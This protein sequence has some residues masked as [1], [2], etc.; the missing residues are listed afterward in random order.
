MDATHP[1]L[2]VRN[3]TKEFH[4]HLVDGRTITPFAG[5][6]FSVPE[7]SLCM[8]AGR[9][10]AGK[11]T[12]LR[13]IY[14]TYLTTAG[15][16]WYDSQKFGR[17]DLATASEEEI[18]Q[19]REREI[20]FCSQFLKV[21]PRVPAL[22]V[23]AEPLLKCGWSRAEAL[24][25]ASRWLKRLG[26]EESR[27]QASPITFSG[28]EQQRINIARAFIAAPRLLLLD[29]PTASLDAYSKSIVLDMISEARAAGVTIVAVSHDMAALR[30][31]ADT[32]FNVPEHASLAAVQES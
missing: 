14:R 10:G 22:D 17:I 12:I 32:I 27:W 31:L 21:L 8:L 30:P 11:T 7:G 24:T 25:E 3:L 9:S 15:E 20:G 4:L 28:G 5:L 16:I 29:E 1:L 13:C 6:S 19:L 18:L 2:E 26:I 23:T